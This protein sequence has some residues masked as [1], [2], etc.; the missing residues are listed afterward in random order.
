MNR[1]VQLVR[2]WCP[3]ALL[4]FYRRHAPLQIR[5][6]GDYPSWQQA[7]DHSAGYQD[8][9][10]IAAIRASAVEVRDG[11]AGWE[12][13]GTLFPEPLPE[14]PVRA[15]LARAAQQGRLRVLDFG[16]ALGTSYQQHRQFFAD[17]VRLDWRIVEQPKL[18]AIGTAEFATAQL[19][20]F[21]D[22]AAATAGDRPHIALLG[23]VL[24][25]LQDPHQTLERIAAT[26][27]PAILLHRTPLIQAERD[28]LTVQRVPAS[29][30]RASYPAWFFSE[31]RLTE[32]MQRL[33]YRLHLQYACDD[34][35]NLPSRY[36][37]LLFETV[38]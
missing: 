31:Q 16:G 30:Y 28:R 17:K 24:P 25:Y 20:F 35:A 9:D 26:A 22:I 5:F 19:R 27:V 12:R 13:D 36:R 3:P 21:A 7:L 23:C 11:R 15:C 37:G 4:A 1:L 6:S 32:Q 14:W 38:D 10:A 29:I 2:Q 34:R 33:G 18:V 8:Q